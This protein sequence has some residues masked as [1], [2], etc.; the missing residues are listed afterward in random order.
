MLKITIISVGGMKEKYFAEAIAEYEKRSSAFAQIK[1]INLK[2]EPTFDARDAEI[3]AALDAEGEQILKNLP[4]RAYKVA[5]CVEGKQLSSE[6]LA[7]KLEK[8]GGEG[9]STVNFV[10]GSSFG[11]SEN[12]K[13]ECDFRLS[14]SP[15]T[16]PHE[17]AR[18]MLFEQV[19]RA[20]SINANSKYH[21]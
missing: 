13:Q 14:M 6:E 9:S 15:M 21:K 17:L 4:P 20:F 3:A 1:N 8:L 10:V 18:V 11:L 5:L 12:F 2:E 19:Y 7:K 16:F